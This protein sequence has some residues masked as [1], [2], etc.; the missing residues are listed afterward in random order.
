LAAEA[1]RRTIRETGA[2]IQVWTKTEHTVAH[3]SIEVQPLIVSCDLGWRIVY[4][5]G[6]LE[7]MRSLR[8]SKLPNETGGVLVGIIDVVRQEIYIV[9]AFESPA[10]SIE[11][12]DGFVR[13]HQGLAEEVERWEHETLTQVEYV[14]EWHSHPDGHSSL[15]SGDDVRLMDWLR[16]RRAKDGR[17]GVMM[18]VAERSTATLLAES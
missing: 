7:R 8:S 1:F 15:P 17:P 11:T 9:D 13:G 12:A 5:A 3:L 16:Q 2:S 6:V 4:D 10:D 14:G 18:I